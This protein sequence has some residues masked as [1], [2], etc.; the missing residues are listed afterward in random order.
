MPRISHRRSP[1]HLR[2]LSRNSTRQT[3]KLYSFHL[4]HLHGIVT[5]ITSLN[6]FFFNQYQYSAYAH[7]HD[8]FI[9]TWKSRPSFPYPYGIFLVYA[10][11]RAQTE[12]NRITKLAGAK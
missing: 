3:F 4:Q 6:T 1:G 9:A 2:A 11:M 12:L 10:R 8:T 5:Y 7:L